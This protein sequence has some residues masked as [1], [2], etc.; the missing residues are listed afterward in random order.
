[1]TVEEQAYS[2]LA[3]AAGATGVPVDRIKPPGDWQGLPRPYIV[4]QAGIDSPPDYMHDGIVPLKA[5][6]IQV[7]CVADDYKQARAVSDQVK[8]ALSGQ[9]SGTTFFFLGQ[10]ITPWEPD[11]RVARVI[12]HFQV[13]STT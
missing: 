6:F 1:V 3:A 4:Q 13:W 8:A 12:L 2:L 7:D 10:P 11:V 5:W 9:H